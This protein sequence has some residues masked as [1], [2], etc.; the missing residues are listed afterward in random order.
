MAETRSSRGTRKAN[1]TP[2]REPAECTGVKPRYSD[3]W[4]L[5][6]VYSLLRVNGV[7]KALSAN[8]AFTYDR[9][10]AYKIAIALRQDGQAAHHR[11]CPDQSRAT[12]KTRAATPSA[13]ARLAARLDHVQHEYRARLGPALERDRAQLAR[14]L[15]Q[16]A[17]AG[18]HGTEGRAV[19]S[20]DGGGFDE[21]R[22]RRVYSG[23]RRAGQQR[24][25]HMRSDE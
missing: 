10:R 15:R 21:A 14:H 17:G 4:N 22:R 11:R 5:Q 18:L 9:Q 16:A 7:H 19:V 6:I 25:S 3:K 2:D 20:E 24:L 12:P 8:S 23:S 13:C 1:S